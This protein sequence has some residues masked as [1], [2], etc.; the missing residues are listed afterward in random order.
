MSIIFRKTGEVEVLDYPVQNNVCR[1][2]DWLYEPYKGLSDWWLAFKDPE[3]QVCYWKI[4][5]NK[6]E[7]PKELLAKLLLIKD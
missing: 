6:S 3:S 4:I 5:I 1:Q 7:V 2:G